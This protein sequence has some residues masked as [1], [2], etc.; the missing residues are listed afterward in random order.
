MSGQIWRERRGWNIACRTA[1]I[2]VTGAL[3]G[4]HIFGI[5]VERLQPWLYLTVATGLALVV[6]EAYSNWRWCF[7]ARGVLPI[8]KVLLLCLVPLVWNYRVPILIGVVVIASIGS[9][10]PRRLRYYSFLERRV[11]ES[12]EGNGS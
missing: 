12:A 5:A 10:M 6:L 11:V 7:Q 4:G 2:T 9:H 1:H 8:T 3:L